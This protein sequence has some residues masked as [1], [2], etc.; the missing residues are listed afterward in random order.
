MKET[1]TGTLLFLFVS[2]VFM[3]FIIWPL[4]AGFFKKQ[5]EEGKAKEYRD[6]VPTPKD[7]VSKKAGFVLV[8]RWEPTCPQI[9][10]VEIFGKRFE[11]LA[12]I[13]TAS[14]D[15]EILVDN[16]YEPHIDYL[17]LRE[18]PSSEVFRVLL[19]NHRLRLLE[20]RRTQQ[21]KMEFRVGKKPTPPCDFTRT[22]FHTKGMES[23]M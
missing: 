23:F 4:V 1:H 3:G 13:E 19:S 7:L 17:F 5:P 14:E 18:P 15:V 12:T 2:I 8:E 21:G 22:T 20:W 11:D 9:P 6:L 16:G 10:Y